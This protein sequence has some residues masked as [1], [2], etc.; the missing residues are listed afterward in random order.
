MGKVNNII[1]QRNNRLTVISNSGE[2]FRDGSILW[3]CQCDCGNIVKL[4][5]WQFRK[6]VSCGCYRE[7][8]DRKYN[9]YEKHG[10]C[11]IVFDSKGNYTIIDTELLPKLKEY[12]WFQ[13]PTSGYFVSVTK[14]KGK[15]I[16][17]HNFVFGYIPEGYEVD[18]KNRKKYDNRRINLRLSTRAENNINHGLTS[19]NTSGYVGVSYVKT[20]DKYRAYITVNYRQISL[21]L[22]DT[23]ESAY[24]AR[25]EAERKYFGEFSS[26]L[27]RKKVIIL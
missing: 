27:D 20:K 17:L 16:R 3:N 18:H 5:S 1:G 21:G 9:I 26:L 24:Q 22:Y 25:L 13:E 12:Y 23:P 8:K 15:R 10:V 11:T 7:I 19:T 14:T 2:Y 4:T 6:A